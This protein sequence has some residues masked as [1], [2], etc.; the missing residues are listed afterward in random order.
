MDGF[1]A[2]GGKWSPAAV[3]LCL[4]C[5][6]IASTDLVAADRVGLECVMGIHPDWV[7][8]LTYAGQMGLGQYDLSKIELVGGTAIASVQKTYKLHKD[9]QHELQWMGPMNELP[10]NLGSLRGPHDFVYG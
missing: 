5:I 6:V 1:E 4:P 8:Y 9:I 3:R 2:D 10:P 7:G